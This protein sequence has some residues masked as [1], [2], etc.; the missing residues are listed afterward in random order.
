MTEADTCR[1]FVVPKLQSAGWE[2]DPHSIAEQRSIT[3]GRIIPVGAGFV[4]NPPKRVDYLLKYTRDFPLAVV[5]AKAAYKSAADGLQQ[6]K[7][8]AEML[9]LKFAY[10]TNGH[11]IIEYDYTSQME[12]INSQVQDLRD[13]FAKQHYVHPEF[14]GSTSIKDVMPVLA[15]NLSYEHLA[16][17]EGATASGKWWTMT[18]TETSAS[19]RAAIADALR[20]YCKLDSY[21]MYAIW[22]ELQGVMKTT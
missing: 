10:A 14:R 1:K 16:I 19:E 2:N 3:D 5:E 7:Q 11:D 15:P 6:A 13:V 4:C 8:Y 17:K 20:V 12:R 9:G 21:A 22:K 18:A